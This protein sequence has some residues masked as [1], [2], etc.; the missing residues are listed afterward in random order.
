MT[1]THDWKT[2]RSP[3][4]NGGG[5][6]PAKLAKSSS[7]SAPSSS[8]FPA[9]RTTRSGSIASLSTRPRWNFREAGPKWRAGAGFTFERRETH[10]GRVPI[11]R[12]FEG[13][14]P[15]LRHAAIQEIISKH[16]CLARARLKLAGSKR[17]KKA[18]GLLDRV[19]NAF[20]EQ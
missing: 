9:S 18:F 12:R 7:V 5:P 6:G 10:L 1:N 16:C 17:P 11:D 8:S 19:A 3:I 20:S 2:A 15:N 13:A 14:C 4:D